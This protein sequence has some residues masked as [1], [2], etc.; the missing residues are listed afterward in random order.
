MKEPRIIL[1]NGQVDEA[2]AMQVILKLLD[3]DKQDENQ[4]IS[5]Y[6]NSPGGSILHG[7]AI[8]DTIKLIK[9][10]VSTVCYGMAASMG[11]F[12][13]SCG[14]KGRRF[15]LPHSRILIHQPL[16]NTESGIVRT[17]SDMQKMADSILKSRNELEKIM[18]ENIGVS[19]EK[20]HHDC[21]RDNWMSANEALE[22]GIIDGI[23]TGELNNKG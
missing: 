11:A 15:A 5:L 12:L 7:L 22:Y 21:E 9:A 13:L 2:S 17:Q 16:I 4:E 19:L 6:I 1:L 20:I 8:Y 10:P 3:F 14:K 23:Y 18:A